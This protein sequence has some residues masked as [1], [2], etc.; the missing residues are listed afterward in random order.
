MIF[1]RAKEGKAG[2]KIV[3]KKKKI[4][5]EGR[6]EGSIL[7]NSSALWYCA[8]SR[9]LEP[10]NTSLMPYFAFLMPAIYLRQSFLATAFDILGQTIL[11]CGSCPMHC[12]MLG[13]IP[14]LY[15]LDVI[16]T[17]PQPHSS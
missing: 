12:G 11:C 1:I 15:P 17:L 6:L 7:G 4:C 5:L 16:S 8:K 13:S 10:K 2:Y 14:R 9:A 3:C